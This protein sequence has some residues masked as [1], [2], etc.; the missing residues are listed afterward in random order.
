VLCLSELR[1]ILLN[2]FALAGYYFR[3]P[4]QLGWRTT[5]EDD[6]DERGLALTVRVTH[7]IESRVVACWVTDRRAAEHVLRFHI[8]TME[9]SYRGENPLVGPPTTLLPPDIITVGE[10]PVRQADVTRDDNGGRELRSIDL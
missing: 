5:I 2:T 3:D 4:G 9:Y 8:D 7:P 10:M 6:D 1:T